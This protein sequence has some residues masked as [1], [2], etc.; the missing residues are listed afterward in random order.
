MYQKLVLSLTSAYQ[1]LTQQSN[2]WDKQNNLNNIFKENGCP[3]PDGAG[4]LF[5]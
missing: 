4:Q 3:V 5:P 2:L 1:S